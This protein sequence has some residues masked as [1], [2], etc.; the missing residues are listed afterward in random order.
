MMATITFATS[1]LLYTTINGGRVH[2]SK[3]R[4]EK[5][6]KKRKREKNTGANR[7]VTSSHFSHEG[8]PS[9]CSFCHF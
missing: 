4:K 3:S 8:T 9:L 7:T 2:P 6:G 5:R 1:L